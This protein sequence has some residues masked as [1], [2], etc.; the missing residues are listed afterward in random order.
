MTTTPSN[1]E[2]GV[3]GAGP[4]DRLRANDLTALT[5]AGLDIVR[6]QLD[7]DAL[8]DLVYRHVL[9]I[10]DASSFHLGLVEGE[11][12]SLKVWI[13]D[14]VHKAPT[15]FPGA[16]DVGIIGWMRSSQVPLLV[17]DF[18][19]E[20]ESLPAR[21][22]YM[23]DRPPRSAIFVP[24][25]A[26]D[27][28]VGSM[29]VQNPEPDA[30]DQADLHLLEIIA[31]QTASAIVNA[32]LY[33]TAQQRA[34]QLEGISD[35]G[36]AI[37]A[38][39]DLDELLATVVE[40]IRERFGYYHVQV[41]LVESESHRAVFR[42]S[43]GHQLNELWRGQERSQGFGEGIIGWVAETGQ[44]L[45]A[46]DVSQEPRYIADDPR[47]LPDTRS[48]LAVPLKVEGEVLGV[49]D[50]QSRESN[51]FGPEDLFVL[52]A[53]A[54]QV[55]VAVDSAWSYRAQQEEAW[56]TTVLLQ[57]AESANRA[58]SLDDVLGVI[59]RLVPLLTGVA[60]CGIWLRDPE[61][62]VFNLAAAHGLRIPLEEAEARLRIHGGSLPV[63]ALLLENP[64]PVTL[65]EDDRDLLPAALREAVWGDQVILLPLL[66]QNR[67]IGSLVVTFDSTDVPFRLHGKRLSM[68]NGIANQ[69]A[70]AIE[71]VRLATA[72][73]EE[74]WISWALL[75]VS[76]AIGNS[77]TVDEM[78]EHI[79]RLTPIL[80]G[81]D[82]CVALM[83]DPTSGE[84]VVA[85]QY[86]GYGADLEDFKGMRVRLGELPLLDLAVTT[87]RIQ[88]VD[89]TSRSNLVPAAWSDRVGSK[90]LLALPLVA[91]DSL[92]G[93]LLVD[94]TVA[95]HMVSQ[96]REDI[97]SGIAQQVGLALENFQLQ[98]QERERVRL[99]QELQVAQRI[100]ASFLP[101]STPDIP[102]YEIA[103]TW[104]SAREVGGDFYDFLHL[105]DGRW[106]LLVGDVADKGVPAALFMAISLTLLR[107]S[108]QNYTLPDAA[109]QRANQLIGANNSTD[110][111]V[112]VW[113]GI[114]DPVEHVLDFA[115]AGHSL[116][117]LVRGSNGEISRLRSSGIPLGILDSAGIGHSRVALELGDVVVLYTDGI[118]D[119][120]NR[121]GEEFGQDRL[122]SVLYANHGRPA[123]QILEAVTS[124]IDAHAD[125]EPIFDDIT[126]SIV[127]RL[128]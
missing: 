35:V 109:L 91:Q 65:F 110:M 37:T 84:F 126:L 124:A 86:L 76:R 66:A 22:S 72:H 112:T 29:S 63:L 34:E 102:G 40:L 127:R 82:R 56:M 61:L 83:V 69:A 87:R 5:E 68:L 118:I 104:Q 64:G 70:A 74:A 60:T 45:L 75:E 59:T 50:V 2:S 79:V 51:G 78:L 42:A 98:A 15:S 21:P 58:D 19:Q 18:E 94:G 11:T 4:R 41:F 93:V 80:A 117:W 52:E 7:V 44:Y 39:L 57:V 24:L 30:F 128:E 33:A 48:E 85:N 1:M 54:N 108:V 36:R 120:L 77:R 62:E 55:A 67:T 31:N 105:A 88:R 32:R 17:R 47:L 114:L 116:A 43:S 73:E 23:A 28:F 27:Q 26:G 125:G 81:V 46:H 106:G 20:M 92:P 101:T 97:L 115:N 113:Y 38:I 3:P 13:Q 95:S 90:T 53:L 89:D 8:C 96:R 121:R 16:H 111:F 25:L 107:T 99:A 119:L 6:S 103:H 49:L 14:G 9:H 71:S 123:R 12:F 10:V 100:Q 122:E